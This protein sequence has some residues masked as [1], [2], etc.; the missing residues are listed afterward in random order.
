M[1]SRHIAKMFKEGE[2]VEESNSH[3]YKLPKG[4]RP[5]SP[6]CL[7]FLPWRASCREPAMSYVK[8]GENAFS[9]Q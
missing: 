6:A 7:I 9:R 1:I 3:L 5:I 4:E 2:L 8:A